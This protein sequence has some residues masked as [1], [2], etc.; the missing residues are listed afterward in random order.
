L[1]NG[2]VEQRIFKQSKARIIET[3]LEANILYMHNIIYKNCP[4][5]TH[6]GNCT[7]PWGKVWNENTQIRWFSGQSDGRLDIMRGGW[8]HSKLG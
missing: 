7:K 3:N 1:T 5:K 2:T 4:K 6:E 8:R